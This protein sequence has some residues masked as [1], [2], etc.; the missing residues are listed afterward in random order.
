MDEDRLHR[1]ENVLN[2]M[3]CNP[4]YRISPFIHIHMVQFARVVSQPCRGQEHSHIALVTVFAGLTTS[5]TLAKHQKIIAYFDGFFTMYLAAIY[6]GLWKFNTFLVP[7]FGPFHY[8]Q[9][10]AHASQGRHDSERAQRSK[11]ASDGWFSK[12]RAATDNHGLA[13]SLLG[14]PAK[15]FFVSK[16]SESLP[17][18]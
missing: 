5:T 4:N 15:N 12:P 9:L 8:I 13:G 17:E 18:M 7:I 10:L 3:T 1:T 16:M 11:R 6:T 2:D 14:W